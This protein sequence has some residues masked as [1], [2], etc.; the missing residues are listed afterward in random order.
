MEAF[1]SIADNELEETLD[2]AYFIQL[3]DLCEKRKLDVARSKKMKL[4]QNELNLSLPAAFFTKKSPSGSSE[5][6]EE[7]KLN[8]N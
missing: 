3:H 7:K 5:F 8:S 6:E 1:I 4:G 2:D